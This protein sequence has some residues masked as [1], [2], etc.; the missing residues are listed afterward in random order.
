MRVAEATI[1]GKRELLLVLVLVAVV[2]VASIRSRET[3]R[4][5]TPGANEEKAS[6]ILETNGRPESLNDLVVSVRFNSPKPIDVGYLENRVI[7]SLAL[8]IDRFSWKFE[9]D[10]IVSG[11]DILR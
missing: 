8:S 5:T 2:S 9:R 6:F 1:M 3:T 7:S 11:H 4:A 10:P